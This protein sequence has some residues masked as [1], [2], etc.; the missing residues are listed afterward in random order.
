[1]GVSLD[2]LS[3]DFDEQLYPH[4]LAALA[5]C[6]WVIGH[7][8]RLAVMK[9]VESLK[10]SQTFTDVVFAR[11]VKGMMEGLKHGVE[12]EGAGRDLE[13]I[14][15]YDPDVDSKYVKA[16]QDLKGLRYPLWIRDLRPSSSQLKIP[17]YPEVCDPGDPW[18]FKEEVLLEDAIVANRSQVKKKKKCRVVYRTHGVGTVHHSRSDGVPVS[19]PTIAPWGLAILLAD[20]ATQTK[21]LTK[22]MNHIQDYSDPSPCH[23]FII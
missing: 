12:H 19:V 9:C 20:V 23:L 22:K 7:G 15:A 14:E 5:G 6:R 17:I 4:M 10:L 3:M 8:L 18:A 11:L 21:R 13:A 16:L 2:K 1:M